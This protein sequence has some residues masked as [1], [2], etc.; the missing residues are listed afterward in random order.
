MHNWLRALIADLTLAGGDSWFIC[1]T[2]PVVGMLLW[3]ESTFFVSNT[4]STRMRTYLSVP[5][6]FGLTPGQHEEIHFC[7]SADRLQ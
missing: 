1:V 4:L 7:L 6:R 3:G 5:A 2:L